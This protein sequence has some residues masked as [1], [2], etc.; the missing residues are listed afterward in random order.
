M[1]PKHL[2]PSTGDPVPPHQLEARPV[3]VTVGR[4]FPATRPWHPVRNGDR[5]QGKEKSN[6]LNSLNSRVPCSVV[7]VV[8]LKYHTLRLARYTVLANYCVR[9]GCIRMHAYKFADPRL[10]DSQMEAGGVGYRC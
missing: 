8:V 6:S 3:A 2:E 7:A 9:R 4:G 1:T 5:A 10:S